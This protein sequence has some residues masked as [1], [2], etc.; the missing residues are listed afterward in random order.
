MN[1]SDIPPK[2]AR[3]IQ[4][5]EELVRLRSKT[6]QDVDSYEAVLWLGR[7][8][9]EDECFSRHRDEPHE[10]DPDL[11]LE[12]R[13]PRE[14]RLAPPPAE[15]E[16]WIG[17][18]DRSD[19]EIEPTLHDTILAPPDLHAAP[20]GYD[21]PDDPD[22][23][24]FREGAE[25]EGAALPEELHLAD[26]PQVQSDWRTYIDSTW[27]PWAIERKRW[28]S[29]QVHYAKLFEIYSYLQTR[30][31]QV[32]LLLGVGLLCWS[33]GPVRIRR[34]LV[35]G[36]VDLVFDESRARFHIRPHSAG[37]HL[38]PELDMLPAEARVPGME[39]DAAQGLNA[40]GDDIWDRG[41]IDLVLNSI[42]HQLSDHGEYLADGVDPG[43][44][45]GEH[46]VV[47]YAPALILRRRSE[48]SVLQFL[49][50]IKEQLDSGDDAPEGWRDLCEA[51]TEYSVDV[52]GDDAS[53]TTETEP[54]Y[55][56]LP[57]N[58]EQR[59]ILGAL[60][61]PIGA[62]VQGP[63][64][65]GKSH[66]I[67]NLV[68]HLLATGKRVLITAQT[69][70]ALE[71]LRKKLPAEI[72][73]LAVS[74][75]GAG[76]DE[77]R[78]LEESVQGIAGRYDQRQAHQY[79]EDAQ[80]FSRERQHAEEQ[81]ADLLHRR[82]VLREQDTRENH[83]AGYIGTA[84]QIARRLN[85]EADDFRWL[86]DAVQHDASLAV[87][88]EDVRA[89]ISILRR[90]PSDLHE[91]LKW[92]RPVVGQNL[93]DAADFRLLVETAQRARAAMVDYPRLDSAHAHL[94]VPDNLPAIRTAIDTLRK[95]EITITNAANRPQPWM[96]R[97]LQQ[98]LTK[99]DRPWFEL[100][101]A[102][103]SSLTPLRPSARDADRRQ[104]DRP[105]DVDWSQLRR[106]A[107]TLR[108]HLD[109][110]GRLKWW[111]FKTAAIKR[112]KYLTTSVRVD[113]HACDSR[114]ALDTLIAHAE[115][116]LGLAHVWKL[117][118][119]LAS[120]V[121]KS[122]ALQ[123]QEIE[124]L[125]EALGDVLAAYRCMEEAMAAVADLP[126][127]TEPS[128]EQTESR[129]ALLG[130]LEATVAHIEF[131]ETRRN[132]SRISDHLEVLLTRPNTDRE[133]TTQLLASVKEMDVVAY[134]TAIDRL[135]RLDRD[136]EDLLTAQSTLATLGE[137]LPNLAQSIADCPQLPEWETRLESLQAAFDH[138]R[139]KQWLTEFIESADLDRIERQLREQE[140]EHRRSITSEAAAL[141]WAH[142]FERMEESHRRALMSW[143]QAIKA[144]GKGTGKYAFRHRR[145]AQEQLQRCRPAIP[146]W[147]MPL[148]RVFDSIDPQPGMFDVVIVDEAS[149]CGPDAL[150]LFYIGKKVL[151]V[152]DDKQISP[153]H[154]GLNRDHVHQ[155]M[156]EFLG[157]FKHS[158][159]F[160]LERS[161]FDHGELR[162]GN[163]I[164]LR[165]HFR[166]MPEIIRF[167]NDL[168]YRNAPL[169]PL[170]QYPPQRLE[171]LVSRH[172]Q[173][174]F[175]EGEGSR[176]INRPEAERLVEEIVRCCSDP[177]YSLN[178]RKP[179]I[180]VISLQ[181]WAQAEFIEHLLVQRLGAEVMAQHRLLCGDAY[182]FQG[183][184]RDLIFLSMV[185]APNARIGALTRFADQQRFNVAAS[186]ARDQLWLFHSVMPE[187]LSEQCMRRKLLEHFL[188]TK[189]TARHV[190]G[191]QVDELRRL[192]LRAD[193]WTDRPPE[194]FESW[195]E[196]DVALRLAS[197]ELRVVPQFEIAG[198]RIDLVVEGERS[199]LAVECD[200]DRW[201]GAEQ[202]EA[203]LERQR[204][205]ER[206]GWTF[207]RVR[208]SAFYANPDCAMRSV[209]DRLDALGIRT[210]CDTS[211]APETIMKDDGQQPVG[212]LQEPELP[213]SEPASA[214]DDDV[215][216]PLP[217]RARGE[218]IPDTAK[219]GEPASGT[220]SS[221]TVSATD[222]VD[223]GRAE[224]YVHWSPTP[225]NDPRESSVDEVVEGL[226][227]IIEAEGPIVGSR[228]FRL[229]ANAAG[230][231]R[232]GSTL[233]DVFNRAVAKARRDGLL[234]FEQSDKRTPM[235][236][237]VLRLTGSP[238][239]RLRTRGD[240]T[241]D[242]IPSSEIASLMQCILDEQLGISDDDLYRRILDHYGF[243]RLRG[244][245]RDRLM[246]IHLNVL[247]RTKSRDCQS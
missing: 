123:V 77:Q 79:R 66:T 67:A 119:G 21:D 189:R 141:A 4:Y 190:A 215:E 212:T 90:I 182:S 2:G 41:A 161:L 145:E 241:I 39:N 143:Q 221:S 19:P 207:E 112:L 35:T 98:V 110:G 113:G 202:Y 85:D 32:E 108:D 65:T 247:E 179:T 169:I 50:R 95:L 34:H 15:C 25:A 225:M 9:E 64:G 124:E 140:D 111:T 80:R 229:Y 244:P 139:A 14:P 1:A 127:L 136:A 223:P 217:G 137:V 151:I 45:T 160:D 8:P 121:S 218:C 52:V 147:I 162:I 75:L 193:R 92:E 37:V 154:V 73:P 24:F 245:T 120:P 214:C 78:S 20:R 186:R 63:P 26:F 107:E 48:R 168:C 101:L 6:I 18:W 23:I 199:R 56:P 109:S 243:Q 237:A 180:G 96:Q 103:E 69:P 170:R 206:A 158:G 142:A 175:R 138:A 128:W 106:D 208:S 3:L 238:P 117:W 89:A 236:Q 105:T 99:R 159:S 88:S 82:R 134:A 198:F 97:A 132:L 33:V 191:L 156:R 72:R 146:A 59:R 102:T 210:P 194:P 43:T 184:E 93:P 30:G 31:E 126:D 61:H 197:E 219:E 11:W 84:E 240:R 148:H 157:D 70:R 171:P 129:A 228:A 230:L 5:L 176:A 213:D 58:E 178:G 38:S 118:A 46:P 220:P 183:D 153:S 234:E 205:L 10:D 167:S 201:H 163:R 81:L 246:E 211:S 203:D 192:A 94:A 181:G 27:K 144:L 100:H 187:D 135:K 57:T 172:V 185:A 216:Q 149:Q 165:E 173:E 114:K 222:I 36:R 227:S 29:V 86:T 224:P 231:R 125:Q 76:V 195:F 177:R 17:E 242:E 55:L 232:V 239:V 12:I 91:R 115:F 152:G 16:P 131:N 54:S 42:S 87:S 40:A 226:L 60:N 130:R 62:L 196:V 44:S 83:I 200:G 122:I 49:R 47:K 174:G 235:Q 166:C 68:C 71:V 155:R 164:V 188:D 13:K 233:R 116:Q 51:S 104:I 53:H 22:H 209:F 74:L 150:P 7:L 28:L 133:I 204:K